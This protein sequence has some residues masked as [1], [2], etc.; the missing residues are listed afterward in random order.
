MS[1][2]Y[3]LILEKARWFAKS[4]GV[5]CAE[6]LLHRLNRLNGLDNATYSGILSHAYAQ[7][8]LKFDRYAKSLEN[9]KP[10]LANILRIKAESYRAIARDYQYLAQDPSA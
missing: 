7:K 10:S 3:G 6:E 9:R 5:G 2:E 1:I 4:G 8:A